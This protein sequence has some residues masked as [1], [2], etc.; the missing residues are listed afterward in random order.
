MINQPLKAACG[1]CG[2]VLVTLGQPCPECQSITDRRDG[3]LEVTAHLV[4]NRVGRRILS[5]RIFDAVLTIG[6]NPFA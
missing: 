2:Q 5:D 6:V 3:R 4:I 1:H